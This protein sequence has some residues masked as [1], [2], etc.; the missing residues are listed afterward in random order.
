MPTVFSKII[1]E[2]IPCHKIAENATCI[3][4][5]DIN[6][7]QH[8]HTLV[9]PKF[10]VDDLF[11]LPESEYT[12]LLS[13]AQ[14]VSKGIQSATNCKRVGMAVIGFDV[15]HAHIHLIPINNTED[16]SFSN[17]RIKQSSNEMQ[18]I[19]NKIAALVIL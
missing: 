18:S 11:N 2:E 14:K 4:F 6:P 12:Q 10:E 16:I 1:A 5:L 9:V 3:A 15:P 17:E 8:G 19:A 7:I 13:F